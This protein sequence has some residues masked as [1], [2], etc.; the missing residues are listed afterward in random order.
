MWTGAA[1]QGISLSV[2]SLHDNNYSAFFT[3]FIT[4]FPRITAS[5]L[6]VSSFPHSSWDSGSV[7]SLQ[8]CHFQNR[9]EAL[10]SPL[11]A[12]SQSVSPPLSPV[13]M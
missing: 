11:T 3:R 10:E 7:K 1:K 12:P 2:L 5:T 13:T 8:M 4:V 6:S 9:P